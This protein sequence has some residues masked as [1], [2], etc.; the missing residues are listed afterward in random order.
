MI[1][2]LIFDMDGVLLDTE[3]IYFS[4][5]QK[6]AAEFGYTLKPEYALAVRSC[7]Q[8]YAESYLKRMLG[9][10]FDYLAVRNRRRELVS[11]Y[12]AEH[13]IVQKPGVAKLVQY[14]EKNG[15]QVAV[16]TAT[17]KELAEERL[18]MA[19]LSGIFSVIV[20]GDQ[21]ERGKPDPD[22]YLT[23][24]R[25]LGLPAEEC[26]AVED[27][28]NGIA[29]AFAAGC[30]PIMVPDLTVPEDCF[31]PLLLGVAADLEQV[32]PILQAVGK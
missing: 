18:A 30:S 25:A 29:A 21:V 5:W 13:G 27:S 26:A 4:C 14:C 9:E 16:A 19:G 7:C 2:G 23:A 20:G 28:P 11:Q 3:R 8:R 24:A 6:S 31:Q 17:S 10:E 15:I 1:R 32:I 22:I 12:I